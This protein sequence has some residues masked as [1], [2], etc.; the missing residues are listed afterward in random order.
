MPT[1]TLKSPLVALAPLVFYL[2]VTATVALRPT[3]ATAS[4]APPC[5]AELRACTG[6]TDCYEC[7]H[8]WATTDGGDAFTECLGIF[9]HDQFD[10]CSAASITP[11]CYDSVSSHDCMGNNAFVEY[12]Q[13]D[14]NERS[15]NAGGGECAAFTCNGRGDGGLVDAA[16]AIVD[17]RAGV[18]EDDAGVAYGDAGVAGFGVLR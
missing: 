8:D 11:C 15:R 18:A 14:A 7:M 12:W 1:T 17:D 10:I 2:V 5:L 4:S 16:A 9:G 3:G 13:C 6:E